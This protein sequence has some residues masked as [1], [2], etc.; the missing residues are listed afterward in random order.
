LKIALF[1]HYSADSD[2]KTNV[3]QFL[4]FGEIK[5]SSKNSFITST[6]D[7]IFFHQYLAISF[8]ENI[9]TTKNPKVG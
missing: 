5:I 8:N 7:G 3:F 1:S 2:I 4:N 9:P 6:T